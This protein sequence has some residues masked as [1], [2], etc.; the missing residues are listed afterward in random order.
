V[1]G[2][3]LR[4]HAS[5][6]PS[7]NVEL[8]HILQHHVRRPADRLLLA[9]VLGMPH[10][11]DPTTLT[12]VPPLTLRGQRLGRLVPDITSPIPKSTSRVL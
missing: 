2:A 12:T 5:L 7:F 8:A 9:Q 6:N 10:L 4:S 3:I 11:S 1:L